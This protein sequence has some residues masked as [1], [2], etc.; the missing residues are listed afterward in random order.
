MKPMFENKALIKG[1]SIQ[2]RANKIHELITDAFDDEKDHTKPVNFA[3]KYGLDYQT[4]IDARSYFME[5]DKSRTVYD[6]CREFNK[7]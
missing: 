3:N 6:W 1:K 5:D 4:L 7:Q 2:Q